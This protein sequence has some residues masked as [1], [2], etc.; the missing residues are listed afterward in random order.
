MGRFDSY[1]LMA[2]GDVPDYVRLKT[3]IFAKD[4]ALHCVEFG[5]GNVNFIFRVSGKNKSVIIKQAGNATRL[6]NTWKI[7]TDRGRIE[8]EY[9]SVQE[10][11]NP[12]KTVKIYHYDTV[13][14]A[15]IMEDLSD[16]DVLR[17]ALLK[18]KTFPHLADHISEYIVNSFFLTSD[19]TVNHEEKKALVK[20]FINPPMCDIMEKLIYTEPYNDIY[21]RNRILPQNICFVQEE[22]YGDSALHLEAAKLKFEYLNSAES[23]IHGDLHTSSFFVRGD[24]I[25]VFDTEFAFFGPAGYDLGDIV[26][27]L[28]FAWANADAEFASDTF[29]DYVLNT[30]ADIIDMFIKK[31]KVRFSE[32]ANDVMAKASGFADWYLEKILSTAAGSC[33]LE[34]ARRTIGMS[35]V[36]D[37]VGIKDESRRERAERLMLRL[38][39]YFTL[40]RKKI[41]TGEDYISAVKHTVFEEDVWKRGKRFYNDTVNDKIVMV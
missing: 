35:Y 38:S 19:I 1:F 20:Q 18:R 27:H 10:K 11:L 26:A 39:K 34:L 32:Y 41:R 24:E 25:K 14:C 2:T 29:K 36:E 40:N 37:L 16:Y 22:F 7:S 12:G 31:F 15:I 8:A 33:G 3:D 28:F 30:I 4:E 17:K 6:D 13:M 9:L 23:L 21:N 5:D